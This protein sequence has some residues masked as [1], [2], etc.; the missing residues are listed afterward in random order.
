MPVYP[1]AADGPVRLAR[2]EHEKRPSEAEL[3]MKNATF[4]THRRGARGRRFGVHGAMFALLL[5]PLIFCVSCDDAV[6]D[7]FRAAAVDSVETGVKSIL[8]GIV[9]GIFT[10]ADPNGPDATSGG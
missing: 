10:I 1:P 6:A 7:E 4:Q 2:S 9:T 5:V 3:T 8:D